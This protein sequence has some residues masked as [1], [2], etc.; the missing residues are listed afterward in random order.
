LSFNLRRPDRRPVAQLPL[1]STA[2]FGHVAAQSHIA[3]NWLVCSRMPVRTDVNPK[4]AARKQG[5]AV[6]ATNGL[7]ALACCTG[8]PAV[9][10]S[11]LNW[12]WPIQGGTGDAADRTAVLRSIKFEEA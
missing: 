3:L 10:W 1:A 5:D 6:A 9:A 2:T 11:A 7:G 12:K 4:M 8:L